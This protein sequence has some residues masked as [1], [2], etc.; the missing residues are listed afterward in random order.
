M[1]SNANARKVFLTSLWYLP[2]FMVLFL[3]HSNTWKQQQEE[4]TEQKYSPWWK[5][6]LQSFFQQTNDKGRQLC[7]HEQ[8][9]VNNN[10]NYCPVT[11]M[12][13]VKAQKLATNNLSSPKVVVQN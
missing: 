5:S 3:L 8:Q 12:G 9:V 10:N 1:G 4:E 11:I 13:K 6:Q 7:L 2:S